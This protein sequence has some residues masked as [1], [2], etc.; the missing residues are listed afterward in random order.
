ME[1]VVHVWSFYWLWSVHE[2]LVDKLAYL[3]LLLFG[4]SAVF[5]HQ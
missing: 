5:A 1:T 2:V 3:N 4:Y